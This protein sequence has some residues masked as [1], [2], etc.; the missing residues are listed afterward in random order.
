MNPY[1][2]FIPEVDLSNRL[3]ELHYLSC[4]I[5]LL[6]EKLP[7]AGE[8]KRAS[9]FK[10]GWV[11]PKHYDR[12]EW[13]LM[14]YVCL[15]PPHRVFLCHQPCSL[16]KWAPHLIR[17]RW[18]CLSWFIMFCQAS[19]GEELQVRRRTFVGL[20]GVSL[21][22][23]NHPRF[24]PKKRKEEEKEIDWFGRITWPVS[25]NGLHVL[26]KLQTVVAFWV[27]DSLLCSLP[28]PFCFC[29]ST[30]LVIEFL[31][32]LLIELHLTHVTTTK[33]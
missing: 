11:P 19:Q 28:V 10:L 33:K 7:L 22:L 8:R 2:L 26:Y 5:L 23:N 27:H 20:W 4:F 24:H 14:S 31:S 17:C 16:L 29:P 25:K 13:F 21:Y 12:I 1:N 15:R 9:L 32:Y 3:W 18:E 6:M 30:Q